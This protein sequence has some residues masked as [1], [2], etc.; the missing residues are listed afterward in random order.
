MTIVLCQ[1]ISNTHTLIW[2]YIPYRDE[3]ERNNAFSVT[4]W[5]GYKET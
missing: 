3:N 4:K 5:T 1:N 2:I